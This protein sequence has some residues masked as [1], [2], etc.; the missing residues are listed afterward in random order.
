MQDED[1]TERN[2]YIKEMQELSDKEGSDKTPHCVVMIFLIQDSLI[3]SL[4]IP[5]ESYETRLLWSEL[6]E[7]EDP[8]R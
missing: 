1:V 7:A 5:K 3:L 8:I 4:K 2:F 6:I